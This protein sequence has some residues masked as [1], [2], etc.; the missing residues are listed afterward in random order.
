[1]NWLLYSGVVYQ[2]YKYIMKK[3]KLTRLRLVFQV[4]NPEY[5]S[6]FCARLMPYLES[7]EDMLSMFRIT[8]EAKIEN[9]T[10][11]DTLY[12]QNKITMFFN[13]YHYTSNLSWSIS[14]FEKAFQDIADVSCSVIKSN[15]VEHNI[16]FL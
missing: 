12:Y 4:H 5:W 6:T 16:A 3:P 15:S 10:G 9:E 8:K 11:I 1:M 13:I 14:A 7:Q 2:A